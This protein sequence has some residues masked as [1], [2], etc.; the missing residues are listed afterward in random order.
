MA[1]CRLFDRMKVQPATLLKNSEA[2]RRRRAD[3]FAYCLNR[4]D[5]M[6]IQIEP[7]AVSR[8]GRQQYGHVRTRVR[9]L[10][11]IKDRL[12]SWRKIY[13]SHS[14]QAGV[15]WSEDEW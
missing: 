15:S 7:R 6:A 8:R 10:D 12:F 14:I 13:T 11:Q 3:V 4:N 2:P 5:W 9:V 1:R